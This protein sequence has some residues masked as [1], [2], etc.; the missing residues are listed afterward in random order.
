M[1]AYLLLLSNPSPKLIVVHA[2]ADPSNQLSDGVSAHPTKNPLP[3]TK[4]KAPLK[5][6]K[7]SSG[8]DATSGY[9]PTKAISPEPNMVTDMG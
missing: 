7:W 8:N 3:P 2:M 4:P 1:H 6:A 5:K 9:L